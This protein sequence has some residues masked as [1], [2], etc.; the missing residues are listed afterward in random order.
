M[1][2][3]TPSAPDPRFLEFV[4]KSE[5]LKGERL[6]AAIPRAYFEPSLPRSIAS[7]VMSAGLYF[8]PLVL[9]AVLMNWYVTPVLIIL[10]GLGGWGL[11]LVAH[12][13]GHGSF[14]RNRKLN[15]VVGHIVS[16][17][18]LYPFHSW[19]HAHNMHHSHTN[20]LTEDRDW[21]P[22]SEAVYRRLPWWRRLGYLSVRTWAVWAGSINY[23][24]TSAFRPS[25]FPKAEMR[26][27]VRRSI[28][29]VLL[30]GSLYLG[31]VGY[32]GGWL[33][34]VLFFVAPWFLTHVWFSITT[35][36]HHSAEDIPF[37]PAQYWTR[38]ASRLLVTT[39]Y[40]YSRWL[41]LLTHYISIHTAHHVAPVIPSHNLLKA[42]AALK[43]AYPGMV[44]EQ[45]AT[46]SALWR[47]L[48]RCR[49]YDPVSGLY[50]TSVLRRRRRR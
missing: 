21:C 22:I 13:C 48:K 12:E 40:V 39:D 27:D 20:S 15:F 41:L 1:S 25:Y 32:L 36:M 17:P 19:R 6:A 31:V 30:G 34:L 4:A 33:G 11:H 45:P 10:S 43:E 7:L 46:V 24:S 16:I 5:E 14:S 49:F 23:W 38:N 28:V 37:L 29:F 50:A 18:L 8:G 3:V 2:Q 26:R 44:R 42:Q 47:I 9:A 35:L